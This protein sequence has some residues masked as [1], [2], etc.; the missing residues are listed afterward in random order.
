MVVVVIDEGG[1]GS[2]EFAFEDVVFEEDTVLEGLVPALDLA[3]G[4]G[5]HGRATDV[6]HAS[7]LELFGQILGNVGQSIITEKAGIVQNLGTLAAGRGEGDVEDIGHIFSPHVAA[8]LPADDVSRIV[9]ENG[10]E[11]ELTPAND[12]QI[13]EVCL[14]HLV[15]RRRFVL[16]LIGRLDDDIGW[17]GHEVVGLE[18]AID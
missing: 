10:R 15:R 7:A 13:G 5:V 8:E 1:D 9:I 2:L 14:P 12:L 3:L 4:L 11:I 16:E 18:R 6:L 17:A